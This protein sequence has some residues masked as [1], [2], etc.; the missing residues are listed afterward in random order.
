MDHSAQT[1][2]ITSK[3]AEANKVDWRLDVFGASSHGYH[4]SSPL[5]ERKVRA[6]EERYSI[7]LPACYRAFVTRIGNGGKISSNPG[8]GPYYGIYPLGKDVDELIGESETH[9]SRPAILH[10][11]MTDEEWAKLNEPIE[12]YFNNRINGDSSTPVEILHDT[13]SRIYSGILP[14]GTQGCSFFHALALNGP[15]AGRVVNI[16]T[17]GQKPKFAFENNFLDWYERW[18][19]EVISGT[20]SSTQTSFGYTMGGD[21]AHLMRVYANAAPEDRQT[22]V[23]AV[24]GLAKLNRVSEETCATLLGLCNDADAELRRTAVMMLTKFAYP[25]ARE[26]LLAH[27]AGNDAD[28]LA[29]CES[30]HWYAKGR[31]TEWVDALRSCLPTVTSL[32]T[33]RFA[34]YVLGA[35]RA[36]YSEELKP[37]LQHP[38]QEIREH[39]QYSLGKLA[40][41]RDR[42]DLFL[43]GLEDPSPQVVGATI[44]ALEGVRDERVTTALD[45]V[46]ERFKTDDQDIIAYLNHRE[47]EMRGTLLDRLKKWLRR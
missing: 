44:R 24:E 34:S 29:A 13:D 11:R 37:F 39:A 17:E 23:D 28:I 12:Q 41:K 18:L 10:P 16:D 9:L 19:D 2:R 38:D 15:H 30:L 36:D 5:S 3:L 1:Q 27:L 4:L 42:V 43:P 40:N 32:E 45:R 35:S 6:F 46:R 21:D 7:Q 14:I 22:R 25:M 47:K 33:L 31:A 8:A 20:L 26:P